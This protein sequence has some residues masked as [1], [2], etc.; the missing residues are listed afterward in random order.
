MLLSIE[1]KRF[2]ITFSVDNL[3]YLSKD[4]LL[5]ITFGL[6]ISAKHDTQKYES[7]AEMML[8]TIFADL[9]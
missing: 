4:Y 9:F 5:E 3:Q 2:T 8:Q 1:E 7:V 6:I